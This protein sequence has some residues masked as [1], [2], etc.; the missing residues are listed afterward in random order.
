MKATTTLVSLLS[1]AAAAATAA[2][3]PA[4]KRQ[5]AA[6][7]YLA[8]TFL[9]TVPSVYFQS[10]P[11][12]TP[13]TF[14]TLNG[15]NPVLTPTQGTKGAR[16]P[17]I[18][19]SNSGDKYYILATDLDISKTDWGTAQAKGSRSIFVWESSDGVNWSSDSLVELMPATA[20]YVWAPSAIWDA[21]KGQYAVF[22]SSRIY[23]EDDPDHTGS[24][25]GPFIFYSHTSDFKTYSTPQ[26]WITNTDAPTIDQEIQVIG[27]AGSNS[28]ARY[29]KSESD[30]NKV[31]LER[32]DSG[33]FG[34]WT[35]IGLPIDAV[36]E[37][38]A[39]YRSI[40]NPDRYYL[41]EDNYSG[42]GS[43]ECYYTDDFTVPY[44]AC[45]P[46]LTP[47]GMRHG[48]VIQVS[49]GTLDALDAKY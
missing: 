42:N 36:R 5:D 20:G 14:T 38:P 9:G 6:A 12:N 23:S 19:R 10:A 1:F 40:E 39:S 21:D 16:D 13:S 8:V 37:G 3:V 30:G 22:W 7:G 43:Y 11:K 25:T 34:T 29:L 18:L 24:F 15:G 48:A 32:S 2:C 4:T 35:R 41:W 28:Y 17:F 49:Q 27:D 31:F 44:A 46:A 26:R 33:L 47:A 45:D